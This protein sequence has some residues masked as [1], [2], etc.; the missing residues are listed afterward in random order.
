MRTIAASA[1]LL[2]FA[3]A[4]LPAGAQR[5]KVVTPPGST[6]SVTVT[7]SG[8]EIITVK[9]ND[10]PVVFKEA[11]P[12][13]FSQRVM[14]PLRGVIEQLGGS[15]LWD[16]KSQT[17]TGAH[18]GSKDQFRLRVGSNEALV[19]GQM[20]NLDAPPRI[21]A[22]TTYVPLRFVSEALRAKVMWDSANRTV[23]ITTDTAAT[24]LDTGNA[25]NP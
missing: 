3:L 8:D 9:L 20:R 1:T 4:A 24:T 15:V 14:I 21:V 18:S 10:K 5:T 6:T 23:L 7:P 25:G 19:N 17:I 13:M 16:A 11:K 22:G 12:R 2:V